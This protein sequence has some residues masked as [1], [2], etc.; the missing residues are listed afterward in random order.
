MDGREK[1]ILGVWQFLKAPPPTAFLSQGT[2]EIREHY[3]DSKKDV[4]RHLKLACEQFIQ[5]QTKQLV[6]PLQEF[7]LKVLKY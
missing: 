3:I 5:Q 6:E 2:P 1:I 4:D 7:L